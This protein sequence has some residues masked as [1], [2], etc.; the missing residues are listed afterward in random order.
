MRL[1]MMEMHETVDDLIREYERAGERRQYDLLKM[2]F[3]YI[4]NL[5]MVFLL[6]RSARAS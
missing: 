5:H 3:D 6:S 4:T 2:V 1:E